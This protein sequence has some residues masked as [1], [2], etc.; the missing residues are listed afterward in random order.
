MP[1]V[2]SVIADGAYPFDVTTLTAPDNSITAKFVSIGAA[3]TELWVKDKYGKFRDVV[4]GYDDQT[5]Y[6]TDPNHPLYG[7]I[8][9]RV[10]NRIANGTFSIPISK[11]PDP[12]AP[13]TYHIPTNDHDGA[14]TLHGGIIGWDRHN[15]TIVARTRNSVT[16]RHL[17]KADEGFPGNVTADVTYTLLNG[18]VWKASIKA[19]ATQLTPIM[20]TSHVYWN[21]DAF[22]GSEDVL[23][24]TLYMDAGKVIE[25]D[26]NGVPTGNFISVDGNAYDFR[27]PQQIGARW[28]Q[29]LNYCGVGCT[30]YDNCWVYDH[31]GRKNSLSMW[32]NVSGIRLDVTTDQVA[33][34]IYTGNWLGSTPRKAVHGGSSKNYQKW[35]AVA[36]EQQGYIDAINNPAWG[37]DQI[38]GPGNDYH[39]NFE[40]KF[41]TVH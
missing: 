13:N 32:S 1:L 4:I 25:I 6:W 19:S 18:G 40:Y 27:K 16:Y 34:Q 5:E 15:F 33:T 14:D 8:A 35:S 21:L 31:P 20:L 23:N 22:Q 29:T 17:D 10:A 9:G 11:N 39:F 7:P 28:D 26:S 12:N 37:Q 36:I 2:K 30:G 3:L 38:H 41:S 24:H